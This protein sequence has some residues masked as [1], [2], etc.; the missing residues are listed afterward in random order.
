MSMH[1]AKL[2]LGLNPSF[3]LSW[4]EQI[5]SFRK[6]GFEAFFTDWRRGLVDLSA[7]RALADEEGM[8]FQSVH[9][10]FERIDTLWEP[11]EETPDVIA[12]QLECLR[13]CAQNDVPIMVAHTFIGFTKHTPTPEGLDNFAILVREAER[14]GVK[15][16]LE[17]TEGEE[18][19][20][21][22]MAHFKGHPNVGF[23][24]D[25]GHELCYN[26]SK[27]MLALYGDRLL[28]T[29][30]NDNLG[31]RDFAGE[32]TFI[33]DLHLL[34]FD[35]V[36]DWQGIADRLNRCG[37]DGPLTFELTR[38]SKPGRHE[39]DPYLRM[40]PIDYLTQVYARACRA[41]T[42]KLRSR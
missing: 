10:P 26:H 31:V 40:E 42:L 19:L 30:L 14:L 1:G 12:E 29:H 25:S 28:C 20:A 41:A 35:G 5:R 36:A 18:Y 38:Q 33:D 7:M 3:G 39:N 23:C 16:A 37:F 21:A 9:A 6:I 22:L 24:W 34:P 17:N 32:I 4:A 27:D 8:L 15:I 11:T 13:L 2:C